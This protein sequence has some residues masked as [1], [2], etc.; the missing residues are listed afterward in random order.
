[1]GQVHICTGLVHTGPGPVPS[2]GISPMSLGVSHTLSHWIVTC[3]SNHVHQKELFWL[4]EQRKKLRSCNGLPCYEK[5]V[6]LGGS[7]MAWQDCVRNYVY[8]VD[9]RRLRKSA[10]RTTQI[11]LINECLSRVHGSKRYERYSV[12]FVVWWDHVYQ[13]WR[14][15]SSYSLLW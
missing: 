3:R 11:E 14:L 4:E 6:K 13:P 8:C 9:P 2:D 15:P 7:I 5:P 10:W 1:M 12:Y